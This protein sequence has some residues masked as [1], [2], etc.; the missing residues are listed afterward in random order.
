MN[1]GIRLATGDI[2]GIL[3]SD[4]IYA[5]ESVIENVVEYMTDKNTDTC[6]GDLMYV[7]REDVNK[8]I[9]YW[10]SDDFYKERFRRGWM[11]PH[12]AFFVKRSIYERYGLLNLDFHLAANYELMLRFLYK[13]NVSTTY[14]PRV[15]VKM[16][17]GGT[18]KPGMYTL[19]AIRENYRAWKVNGLKYPITILLKPLSKIPQFF[20]ALSSSS[21]N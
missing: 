15:L 14:I 17:M 3:N 2:V 13:Y 4:D 8:V 16:R 12:P 10:K 6:Y 7:E 21:H 11:P 9:R 19:G 5:D 20:K 18:S 1:K